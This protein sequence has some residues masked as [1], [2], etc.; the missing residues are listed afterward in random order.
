MD[1]ERV[2]KL[3]EAAALKGARCP[4]NH[5][6]PNGD[7]AGISRLARMGRL[8][9]EISGRNWR[10]VTILTGPNKGRYTAPN[11]MGYATWRILDTRNI[12]VA[13]AHVSPEKERMRLWAPPQGKHAR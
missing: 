2:F 11:P 3:V 10:Q 6:L 9:I 4:Q 5:E 1:L 12:K 13:R 7:F 8:R